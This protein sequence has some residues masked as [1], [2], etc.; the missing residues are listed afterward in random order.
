VSA[1]GNERGIYERLGRPIRSSTL[2]VLVTA[3]KSEE[4]E[5]AERL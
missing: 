3:R 2:T 5:P 1:T 4:A